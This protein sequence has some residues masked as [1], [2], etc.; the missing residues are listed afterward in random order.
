MGAAA[1]C[2]ICMLAANTCAMSA[3]AG[4]SASAARLASA[5]KPEQV[6][7]ESGPIQSGNHANSPASTAGHGFF[8]H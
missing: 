3:C 8:K 6:S 1:A 4:A 2:V 5:S 7:K